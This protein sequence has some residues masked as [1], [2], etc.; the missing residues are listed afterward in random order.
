MVAWMVWFRRNQVLFA[1]GGVNNLMLVER[2]HKA[3]LD[4]VA[5]AQRIYAPSRSRE[6][7]G[8][9][10]WA[11]PAVGSVKINSDASVGADG[12]IGLGAVARNDQ[13]Q[14]LWSVCRRVRA[15]WP[16]AVAEGKALCLAAR[17]ARLHNH[18]HVIFESDCLSLV[19]RLSKGVIYFSDL[20]SI[21][22]DILSLCNVFEV[23]VW[24]HVRREGNFVAHHLARLMPF[25][26]E[27]RWE[28]HV[29]S[30]IA[31]YVLM[32]SLSLP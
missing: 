8:A 16:V 15:W 7:S 6:G 17:L 13:G 25:G 12:W 11:P 32:D 23:V 2:A 18:S 3:R 31:P 22:A 20:D 4:Y 5:Y 1:G 19:S 10:Q 26:I 29:P 9:R 14:V 30:D 27:Q 21:L 24:S 28:N